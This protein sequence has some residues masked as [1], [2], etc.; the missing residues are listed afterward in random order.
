MSSFLNAGLF[1]Q[2]SREGREEANESVGKE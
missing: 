2:G 1:P